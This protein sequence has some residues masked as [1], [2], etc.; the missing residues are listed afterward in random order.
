MCTCGYTNIHT[1]ASIR[2]YTYINVYVSK[3]MCLN[4][5]AYVYTHIHRYLEYICLSNHLHILIIYIYVY[6]DRSPHGAQHGKRLMANLYHIYPGSPGAKN[7]A[8][9]CLEPIAVL[10]LLLCDHR[11]DW[12]ALLGTSGSSTIV[13]PEKQ[14]YLY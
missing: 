3:C 9:S 12:T 6:V 5:Y 1:Y 14:L 4:I 2:I 11:W 10:L 13:G 7:A 8:S